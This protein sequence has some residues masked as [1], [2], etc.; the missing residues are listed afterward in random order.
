MHL[1]TSTLSEWEESPDDVA[2]ILNHWSVSCYFKSEESK[3]GGVDIS[4]SFP[5]MYLKFIHIT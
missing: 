1:Q 3:L 5:F 2:L 4:S